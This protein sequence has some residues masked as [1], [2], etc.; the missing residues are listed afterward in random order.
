VARA[1]VLWGLDLL[2]IEV[3]VH[4]NSI[5]GIEWWLKRTLSMVKRVEAVPGNVPTAMPRTTMRL[6]LSP[7]VRQP[8]ERTNPSSPWLRTP[9]R[10][11]AVV[12]LSDTLFVAHARRGGRIDQ[13]VR[14]RLAEPRYPPPSTCV[15][16]APQLIP[17][18]LL[19]DYLEQGATGWTVDT[20]SLDSAETRTRRSAA[21]SRPMPAPGR[22]R[23][24][25]AV[26]RQ[27]H[28]RRRIE[29]PPWNYLTHTTR[30][31]IGP[32]P[33][34]SVE[35][36]LDELILGRV[37][38]DRSP[39]ASLRRI[40][41]QRRIVASDRAVRGRVAVS[42]FT[43]VRL[44]ELP[45]L[46]VFRP[47]RGRWDFEPYGVLID[48][49]WLIER[50]ARPVIYGDDATWN[51]LTPSDQPFFQLARSHRR[52]TGPTIDWTR[53]Q[54]WRLAGDVDLTQLPSHLGLLFV[55]SRAEAMSLARW[56]RW[57]VAVADSL[58]REGIDVIC[59]EH[60]R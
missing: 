21:I 10:D 31:A 60:D 54:E 22:H 20:S 47:H 19:H 4:E 8:D 1:A 26:V 56:S 11:R 46:R 35:E 53:E 27:P 37:E 24:F 6:V 44:A 17:P 15:A 14:A 43:A 50:G 33:G 7:L 45:S 39:L 13:L 48:R 59:P 18:D 41:V 29:T 34:Q 38:A 16:L 52:S 55:P 30:E 49:E 32:W 23:S 12:A 42:C 51:R 36:H 5:A 40:A 28:R 2:R 25:P 57:P 3:P 58:E 9:L